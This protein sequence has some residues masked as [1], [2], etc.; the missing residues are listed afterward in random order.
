MKYQES[1]GIIIYRMRNNQREYLLLHYA[2]GH[3]DLPKGKLEAGETKEQAALR[4]LDEETGL[5]AKIEPGFCEALAYNFI[6]YDGIPAHKKVS[7]FI[8]EVEGEANKIVLSHEHQDFAWLAYEQAI[9][10][11]T[12]DNAR[13][14]LRKAEAFIKQ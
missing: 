5:K 12:Y 1:A 3:W 7:F 2:S 14:I 11:L 13:T 9:K 4:E 8:G 10:R 6:D